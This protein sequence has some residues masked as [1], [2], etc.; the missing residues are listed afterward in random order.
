MEID[1]KYN[2]DL[3]IMRVAAKLTGMHPQT[4]RKY[5]KAGLLEPSRNNRIRMYSRE[6]LDRLMLIK[7]LVEDTGLNIAGVKMVL[8]FRDI[9]QEVRNFMEAMPDSERNRN[10][11]KRLNDNISKINDIEN[12]N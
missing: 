1:T 2:Q 9:L 8:E 6:D 11:I 3:Y 10:L 4:L 5:E 7:N 12:A